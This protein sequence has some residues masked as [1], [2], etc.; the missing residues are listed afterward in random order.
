MWGRQPGRSG[1]APPGGRGRPLA[2]DNSGRTFQDGYFNWDTGLLNERAA[3]ER[4]AVVAW[5]E[6]RGIPV[7]PRA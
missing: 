1:A 6:A 5:L 7:D 2:T 3:S 4:A